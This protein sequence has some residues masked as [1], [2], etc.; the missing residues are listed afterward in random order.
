M[1]I[2][3]TVCVVYLQNCKNV[4]MWT[5]LTFQDN[6]T[7]CSNHIIK[8]NTIRNT[9]SSNTSNNL[10]MHAYTGLHSDIYEL[11]NY[12]KYE[13]VC[14][15]V[16]V[17]VHIIK[18]YI[19]LYISIILILNM[20]VFIYYNKSIIINTF[21]LFIISY[22]IS[23]ILRLIASK[24][25]VFVYL[26]CVYCVYLLCIYKYTNLHA[27]ILIYKYIHAC[28]YF[29]CIKTLHAYIMKTKTLILYA[30]NHDIYVCV[31]N[32]LL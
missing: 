32:V 22:I 7:R 12:I 31:Y 20:L 25:K 1:Y 3:H 8:R 18:L 5:F 15:C 30:I 14:M 29:I 17:Y 10:F 9:K 11:Y 26:I 2:F 6:I 13:V 19:T 28:A 24:I 16:C 21:Y 23:I 27:Y 4:Q